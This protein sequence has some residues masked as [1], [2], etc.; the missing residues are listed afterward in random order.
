[1]A[2]AQVPARQ[3]VLVV[4]DEPILMMDAVDLI[5]QAGFEAVE[6]TNADEAIKILLSRPD[7]HILFT[8]IDMPGS[9]DG[10]KLAQIARDRWPPIEIIIVSGHRTVHEDDM[11]DRGLFFAKPYSPRAVKAALQSFVA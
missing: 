1:M 9:M 3:I 2:T 5:E 10:V 8:D 7:I 11:P 4:E 6:A